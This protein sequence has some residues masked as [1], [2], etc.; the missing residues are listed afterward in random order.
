MHEVRNAY[1]SDRNEIYEN[2]FIDSYMNWCLCET[3]LA[4]MEQKVDIEH[5]IGKLKFT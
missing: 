1:V 4:I 2:V 3:E 5:I